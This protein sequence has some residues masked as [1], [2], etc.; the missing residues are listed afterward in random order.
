MI[1]NIHIK[2][3]GKI[4]ERREGVLLLRPTRI[5]KKVLIF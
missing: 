2:R 5:Y 4:K 1:P 3:V